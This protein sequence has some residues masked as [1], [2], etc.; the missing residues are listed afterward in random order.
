MSLELCWQLD[1][2][3]DLRLCLSFNMDVK[4]SILD[5][6]TCIVSH[7]DISLAAMIHPFP[8]IPIYHEMKYI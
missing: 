7:Y 1:L 3:V 4:H 8:L 2:Q 5:S 6:Q